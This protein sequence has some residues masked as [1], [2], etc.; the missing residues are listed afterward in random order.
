METKFL[1]LMVLD[2]LFYQQKWDVIGL[3]LVQAVRYF[4]KGFMQKSWNTTA[5]SLIPKVNMPVNIKEYRP[6][7]CCNIHDKCITKFWLIFFKGC[8][9]VS[10]TRT[11]LPLL[12]A[13]L[14]LIMSC[15]CKKLLEDI[16]G[17]LGL[18]VAQLGLI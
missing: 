18:Q 14:L 2:L 8:S 7:S 13:D 15:R 16:I 3:E 4:S 1:D 6:I 17:I 12:R 9:L 5:I 10:L 11:N